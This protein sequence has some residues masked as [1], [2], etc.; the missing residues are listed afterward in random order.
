MILPNQF[1]VT[2]TSELLPMPV[3]AQTLVA[4]C[5]FI[6]AKAALL[7]LP[8]FFLHSPMEAQRRVQYE[9]IDFDLA[10]GT[11][12]TSN[13]VSREVSESLSTFPCRSFSIGVERLLHFRKPNE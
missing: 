13:V 2:R 1:H 5:C 9:W 3:S 11:T 12:V 8:L 4:P 10:V 7:C 6:P